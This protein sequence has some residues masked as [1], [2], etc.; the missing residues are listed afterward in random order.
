MAGPYDWAREQTEQAERLA[1][2]DRLP[3]AARLL[4]SGIDRVTGGGGEWD[5]NRLAALAGFAELLEA[6]LGA[7]GDA[8]ALRRFLTGLRATFRELELA[9]AELLALG[10]RV[11]LEAMVDDFAAAADAG[12]ELIALWAA[13]DWGEP[14]PDHDGVG[15]AAASLGRAARAA[16]H[17]GA[18]AHAATLA[19][20]ALTLDESEP[21]ALFAE[22]YGA[23]RQGRLEEALTSFDR[24]IAAD[25]GRPGSHEGRARVLSRLD[26]L[27]EAI[28]AMGAA[29]HG[30]PAQP[31]HR[32]VRAEFLVEAGRTEE[33]LVDLTVCAAQTAAE[34]AVLA[35]DPAANLPYLDTLPTEDL[36]VQTV[37]FRMS[38]L[39]ESGRDDD[40][41]LCA[42]EALADPRLR[43]FDRLRDALAELAGLLESPAAILERLPGDPPSAPARAR[44]LIVLDEVERAL[45]VLEDMRLRPY[46]MEGFEALGGLLEL[47]AA[48][49]PR[50]P[51]VRR[52]LADVLITRWRPTAA[53]AHVEVLLEERPG[54]WYGLLLRGM[55]LVTHA[56][57]EPGWN[58]A[59]VVDALESLAGAAHAAPPGESRPL[60]ALRWLLQLALAV[61]DLR[62]ALLVLIVRKAAPYDRILAVLPELETIVE[63]LAAFTFVF[64]PGQEH[65]DSARALEAAHER[66]VAAGFAQLAAQIDLLHADVLLRLSDVQGA[67]DHLA[68][69]EAV[70]FFLGVIPNAEFLPSWNHADLAA[71][72]AEVEERGRSA[73]VFDF[74]H[75]EV[76]VAALGLL[77]GYI[78]LVHA[79]L[80]L[81]LGDLPAA[82]E[83][84]DGPSAGGGPAY[85]ADARRMLKARVLRDSGRYEE[86]LEALGEV[87]EDRRAAN[88][89]ATIHRLRGEHDEA[90]R[91]LRR[92]L[93]GEDLDA[94][95][96]LIIAG[97]LAGAQRASGQP[98]AALRTLDEHPP[99]PSAPP[100]ARAT[101]HAG[102]G[103]ALS[104]MGRPARALADLMAA[105]DLNDQVRGGLRAEDDRIRWQAGGLPLLAEALWAA[106][107]A[108]RLDTALELVERGRARA[109]VDGLTLG[110]PLRGPETAGLAASV[111]AARERRRLLLE[112]AR[113][114]GADLG[115]LRALGVDLGVRDDGFGERLAGQI[116]REG[117]ALRR[118]EQ[119]LLRATLGARE[120]VAGR[121]SSAAE[122]RGLLATGPGEPA[123]LLAEFASTGGGGIGLLL[124]TRDGTTWSSWPDAEPGP[125]AGHLRRRSRPGE[126]ICLVPSGPL[127]HLP[128]H[129]TSVDGAP[130]IARNPVCYLPSASV[131]ALC[132]A[133]RRPRRAFSALVL[134]DSRGDLRHARAEAVA[135]ADLLGTRAHLGPAAVKDLLGDG[136]D[137]IHLACHAAFDAEH[138]EQ[139][140]ILLHD[141]R[142]TVEDVYDLRLNASLVVLSACESGLGENRPGD[143]L[144]G[145]VRAFMYAGAAT[146]LVSLWP[147]DDLSTGLLMRE[148]YERWRGGGEGPAQALA[149]AQL[150]VGDMTCAQAIGRIE[151]DAGARLDVARLRVRAGD[152][153]AAIALYEELLAGEPGVPADLVRRQLRRLRLKAEAP[154]PVDYGRRPFAD[155]YHWAAFTLVGD[156]R[157][158]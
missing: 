110:P 37:A 61:P 33:A 136:H 106:V 56:E 158:G 26:R 87:G 27:P 23:A 88:V 5:E 66:A 142:L 95:E 114:P 21:S 28:E 55:A 123:V 86:A 97:N 9:P 77:Q 149:A 34:A 133:R 60:N 22:A 85:L 52:V 75:Q 58:G 116:A 135:V 76:M 63:M 54:D 78:D 18:A 108:A 99:G 38:L 59:N 79:D 42:A 111:A 44:C 12:A 151:S 7:L 143:E 90:A 69:A 6:V 113:D 109:F 98:R 48:R 40:A 118:L 157:T 89:L 107:A 132:R 80:A 15:E 117:P 84:L 141:A 4:Q 137:V 50:H 35:A 146:L 49:H 112:A 101:W 73:M 3:E 94:Y 125:L 72:R 92:V 70:I 100:Q 139:S 91:I 140:G 129:A 145:L 43:G 119:R 153:G 62:E 131:L 68:A 83:H 19:R 41:A 24:L 152:L 36:A 1:D 65:E 51:G 57:G 127:H 134:G 8:D 93:G 53:L 104:S 96:R 17:R 32:L 126:L 64:N 115:P 47:L 121:V 130:L 120:S 67:M 81:R 148:F 20:F 156:W 122:V 25:P 11:L 13:W 31:R 147:V 45:V 102:R 30:E 124:V 103:R 16:H 29:V 105:L 14:D 71:Q 2:D 144:M 74:D 82:L 150:A 46:D 128:L 155:P 10:K 138:P 154:E 39:A